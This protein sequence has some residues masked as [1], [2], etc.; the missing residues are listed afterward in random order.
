MISILINVVIPTIIMTRFAD[1]DKLGAINALLLALAFPFIYGI[2]EMV[3]NHKIGWVP[4]LGLV[5]I[6]ISGGIGLLELPARWIAVKEAMIPAI[7][8]LAILVSG[9][10]GKPLARLFLDA[11]IDKEKIYPILEAQGKMDDYDR[12]TSVATWMLAGTFILSAVLNF[13]LAR[14]VVTADGGTQQY[15]EQIGRMTALSFPVI[16]IPVFIALT[17]S[18]LYIMSTLS[19]LTG[20]EMDE[21]LKDQRKQKSEA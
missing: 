20:L 13:I 17:A 14:I 6:A 1:D 7:L 9:W 21:V 15:T 16:T 4:V 18:I 10:I 11:I 19:K 2:Y 5:S 3:R 12:R 8:A